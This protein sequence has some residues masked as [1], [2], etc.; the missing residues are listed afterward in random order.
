MQFH[1]SEF[2]KF[3]LEDV[4]QKQAVELGFRPSPSNTNV[5]ITD[6]TINNLSFAQLATLSPNHPIDSPIQ[7]VAQP[8]TGDVI[9]TL[10]STWKTLYPGS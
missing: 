6:S 8:P 4:Q 3:L 10:L 1:R 5:Q 2:Q 7:P 9:N